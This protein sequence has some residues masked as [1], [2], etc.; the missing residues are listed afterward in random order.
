MAGF[1]GLVESFQDSVPVPCSAAMDMASW[2]AQSYRFLGVC[3]VPSECMTSARA[4]CFDLNS[5]E[6]LPSVLGTVILI[7]G[8]LVSL[9]SS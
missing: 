2:D 8:H 3:L 1:P 9:L 7:D 6:G 4:H 5:V